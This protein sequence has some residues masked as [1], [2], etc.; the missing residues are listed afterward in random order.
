VVPKGILEAVDRLIK[1][2]FCS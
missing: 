2:H 1:T